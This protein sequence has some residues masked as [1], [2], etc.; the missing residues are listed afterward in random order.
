MVPSRVA[1][2]VG[3]T[4][5]PVPTQPNMLTILHGLPPPLL[6]ADSAVELQSGT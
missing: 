3:D 5:W 1:L 6:H 2:D 4:V